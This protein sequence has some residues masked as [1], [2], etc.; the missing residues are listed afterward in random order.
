MERSLL[1][2]RED[3]LANDQER[4]FRWSAEDGM[5]SIIELNFNEKIGICSVSAQGN[6]VTGIITNQL[7]QERKTFF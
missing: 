6:A 4:I 1:D 2:G 5:R 3:G 7:T